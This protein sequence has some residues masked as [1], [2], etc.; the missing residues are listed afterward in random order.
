MY[1]RKILSFVL[2][3]F[4]WYSGSSRLRMRN[5][6]TSFPRICDKASFEDHVSFEGGKKSRIL[7]EIVAES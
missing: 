1:K 3:K 4:M 2:R 6:T 5:F 7:V